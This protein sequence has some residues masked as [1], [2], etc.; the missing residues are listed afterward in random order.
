MQNGMKYCTT[1]QPMEAKLSIYLVKHA[2]NIV[3]TFPN[4]DS[5]V[6]FAH[7]SMDGMQ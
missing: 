4:T 5:D 2:Q 6:H 7:L 1:I 3:D